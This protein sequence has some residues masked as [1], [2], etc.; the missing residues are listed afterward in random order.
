MRCTH[1]DVYENI[2]FKSSC[3]NTL[4]DLN[5]FINLALAKVKGC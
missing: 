5:N 1:E 4:H 2:S 3:T